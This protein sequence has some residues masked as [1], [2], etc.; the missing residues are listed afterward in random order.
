MDTL[1]HALSGALVARVTE[2]RALGPDRL[3]RRLRMW[4]GFWAAAFPD[5]D[6]VLG[7]IDPLTYLATHRGLTHSVFLLPVWAA[8]LGWLF[9]R[10]VRR[11]Y[12]WRAFA[13]VAALGIGMHIAGDVITAYGTM[14]LTPFSYARISWP[15]TFIIDPYF[16]AIIVA[17]LI[18]GVRFPDTRLPA[19]L[20]LAALA[21]Y[22]GFQTLL[23]NQAVAI[24]KGYAARERLGAPEVYA[25]PQP[26]SPFNWMIAIADDTT[27]HIA[28]VNLI[29]SEIP[30][31][32]PANAYW[33]RRVWASYHPV[34]DAVWRQAP[35]FG[36][37]AEA[38][39]A[40]EAWNLPGFAV[41]RDF[42]LLPA[43]YRVD[44]LGDRLCAWFS[45]LRF[46]LVGRDAIFRYGACRAPDQ[47]WQIYRLSTRGDG[48]DYADP[49]RGF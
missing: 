19:V 20:G 16:T 2:P 38:G 44:R 6:F 41:Y 43:L 45:D 48:R 37:P 40:A 21:T 35:R 7:F 47:P 22:V 9:A 13:G 34:A 42:A 17:G 1:T 49:V 39:L 25:I 46:A 18:I 23:Q 10:I 24:G 14:L 4:I 36:A 11:G 3:P 15:T 30:E 26:F 28:Y 27:Y 29:R 31:P 8:G 32:P 5:S 33:M 12:S